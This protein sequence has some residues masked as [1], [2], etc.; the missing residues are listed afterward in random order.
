MS[1][2]NK[3]LHLGLVAKILCAF[4]TLDASDMPSLSC[5]YIS[6]WNM[7]GEG[8]KS[9]SSSVEPSMTLWHF[10][11]LTAYYLLGDSTTGCCA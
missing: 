2:S 5:L 11:T 4:L 6:T 8:Y 10:L 3:P 1:R 9:L 7:F